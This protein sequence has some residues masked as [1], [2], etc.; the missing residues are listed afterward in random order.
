[1]TLAAEQLEIVREIV[2]YLPLEEIAAK[3]ALLD[4]VG[5]QRMSDDVSEWE[6]KRQKFDKRIKLSGGL[7][8][9]DLDP[10]RQRSAIRRRVL[11]RLGLGSVMPTFFAVAEGCRGR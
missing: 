3:C 6:D 9:V 10:E 5:E 2:G 7:K 8:G 1:M 11:D 4:S